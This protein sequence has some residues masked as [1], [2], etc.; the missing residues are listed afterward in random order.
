MLTARFFSDIGNQA[1]IKIAP[2]LE[3]RVMIASYNA[4]LINPKSWIIWT[5]KKMEPHPKASL[6]QATTPVPWG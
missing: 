1:D 5:Q 6:L 4:N 2:V 3:I